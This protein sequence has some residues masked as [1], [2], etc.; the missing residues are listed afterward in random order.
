MSLRAFVMTA[1]M[2]AALVALPG[3]AS[4]RDAVPERG[5]LAS[6]AAE[7]LRSSTADD[8]RLRVPSGLAIGAPVNEMNQIGSIPVEARVSRLNGGQVH[9]A[10][11]LWNGK[12][13]R[14]P[15]YDG[16]SAPPRAVVRVTH[17]AR[18]GDPLAPRTSDFTFGLYFKKDATSTGTP[19]DNGDN[20]MQ[21]GLASDPAQYKLEVDGA[22]P[23][24]TVKGDRGQV[25]VRSSVSVKSDR[26]YQAVCSRKGNTIRLVV[27]E[28]RPNGSIQTVT[29]SKSGTIGSLVWP[30]RETPI[31]I[32]GKLAANG[33][34]IRSATDQ[35]NGWATH[36]ELEIKG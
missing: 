32:G 34:V 28:H 36:P 19:V 17:T 26:W 15:A 20:L 6:S 13:L 24:C 21:R 30:K 12:G 11:N 23:S 9:V 29:T 7:D 25:S 22:R 8:I 31:A 1:T 10:A 5:P 35:F 16:K 4:A 27:H 14:F 3:G 2:A 18:S 33:A